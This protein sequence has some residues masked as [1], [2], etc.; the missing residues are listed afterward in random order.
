M[1]Q[2]NQMRQKISM[3]LQQ[4][5]RNDDD[6]A[7]STLRLML[8]VIKDADIAARS[9]DTGQGLS[10]ENIMKL[11]ETMITQ[12]KKSEMIYRTHQQK[13]RAEREIA[14]MNVISSFLP[15]KMNE[16]ETREAVE[17]IID[18]LKISSPKDRG[19][20]INAIKKLYPHALDMKTVAEITLEILN[21]RSSSEK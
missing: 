14:E 8:A 13:E 11:L 18:D 6:V 5:M 10:D 21:K 1:E 12:R 9:V 16:N 4:A 20:V 15:K 19:Q 3:A 17:M 2:E 7:R